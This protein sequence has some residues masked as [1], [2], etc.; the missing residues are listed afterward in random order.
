MSYQVPEVRKQAG[1]RVHLP[2]QDRTGC[3]DLAPRKTPGIYPFL[4]EKKSD[5]AARTASVHSVVFDGPA[6]PRAGA[7]YAVLPP[8][9]SHGGAFGPAIS[10]AGPR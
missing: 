4:C 1:L 3:A 6:V 10:Y 9:V 7:G 8:P 5:Y 2:A